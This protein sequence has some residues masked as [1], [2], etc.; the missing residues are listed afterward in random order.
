MYI[1]L[2]HDRCKHSSAYSDRCLATTLRFPLG[3]ERYCMTQLVDDGRTA[4]TIVL[5]E[6]GRESTRVFASEK[7]LREAALEGPMA[8]E[9][10]ERENL[11]G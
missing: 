5:R 9:R 7:E 4:I 8:F 6:D 2:D 3:H 11:T 1:V 10:R